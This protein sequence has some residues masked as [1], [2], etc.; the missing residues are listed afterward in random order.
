LGSFG[1]EPSVNSH[2]SD[3]TL[4]LPLPPNSPDHN[5]PSHNVGAPPAAAKLA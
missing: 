5:C 2:F 1:I 3:T 4:P